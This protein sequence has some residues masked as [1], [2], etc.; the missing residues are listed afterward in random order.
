MGQQKISEDGA[1]DLKV[2][3]EYELLDENFALIDETLY[4]EKYFSEK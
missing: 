2:E 3:K 4:V 1:S